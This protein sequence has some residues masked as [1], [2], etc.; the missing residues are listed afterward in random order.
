MA[1]TKI[2]SDNEA[3]IK[4]AIRSNGQGEI[5]GDLLQ[6]KMLL[7]NRGAFGG[8]IEYYEDGELVKLDI[9]ELQ[10]CINTNSV[11]VESTW[12]KFLK[13][14]K[15]NN[16]QEFHYVAL[17]NYVG[18]VARIEA[19]LLL[20]TNYRDEEDYS[21]PVIEMYFLMNPAGYI[22]NLQSIALVELD[23]WGSTYFIGAVYDNEPRKLNMYLGASAVYSTFVALFS[24]LQIS[25]QQWEEIGAGRY[26]FVRN[27]RTGEILPIM[28]MERLESR[29]RITVGYRTWDGAHYWQIIDDDITDTHSITLTDI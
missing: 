3:A 18:G 11:D 21:G 19:Y 7:L 28:Q 13:E 20:Y 4:A 6:E 10:D 15:A 5:T 29:Q 16:Y 22:N 8:E 2:I 17:W 12:G 23:D 24:A 26:A 9:A 25:G 27:T 1:I 14:F